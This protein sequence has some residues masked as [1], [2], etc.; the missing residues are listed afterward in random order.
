MVKNEGPV[1]LFE[2]AISRQEYIQFFF[3]ENEYFVLDR[4][5]GE[6]WPYGSFNNHIIPYIE[7]YGEEVFQKQFW[8]GIFFY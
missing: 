1:N 2:K 6:H 5:V 7:R 3:G 4:E 8:E